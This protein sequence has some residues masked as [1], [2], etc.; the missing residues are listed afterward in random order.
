VRDEVVD[1]CPIDVKCVVVAI[2]VFHC[3]VPRT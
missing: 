3:V 1:F 2:C